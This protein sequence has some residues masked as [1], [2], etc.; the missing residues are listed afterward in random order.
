LDFCRI[1]WAFFIHPFTRKEETPM[2][3]ELFHLHSSITAG[4][5]TLGFSTPTAIQREA[6]P[7]VMAGRDVMGLAQTGTGKTAAFG[8][9]ILHRLLDGP[10]GKVRALILGPTRELTEQTHRAIGGMGRSTRLRSAAI[11]GGV[12]MQ[13]QFDAL[14]RGVDIVAACPGRLLDHIRRKTID[15]SRVEV[16]V[17]DEADQMFDMGFLP[18]IRKI[19]KQL[20]RIRQN[21]LFSATMPADIKSLAD[22]ILRDPVRVKIGQTAPAASVAHTFYPVAT[23][24][25]DALLKKILDTT[26]TGA[27]LVFTRTKRRSK[28]LARLLEESGYEAAA[29]HGNLSQSNRRK[30]MEGFRSGRYKILVATDVAARGIDVRGISHVINYDIPGTVD[31]YTHRIGRTGRACETGDAFTFVCQEDQGLLRAITHLLGNQDKYKVMERFGGAD[32]IREGAQARVQMAARR[33]AAMRSFRAK[34]RSWTASR[35]PRSA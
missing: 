26:L 29:L 10:Q 9:P 2:S 24:S 33:P 23:R 19:V 7:A 6:I 11:Y 28:N 17:L 27:V 25:K 16:L 4:V 20:P 30:A 1:Q 13:P 18:E 35:R 5:K 3:F 21:L 31:A 15:L 12:G 8:L 34:P 32:P 22:E 14:R